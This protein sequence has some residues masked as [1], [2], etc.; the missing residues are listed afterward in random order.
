MAISEITRRDI[1]DFITLN[2]IAWW[3]RLEEPAFLGRLYD[4][5]KLPSDDSRY[6]TASGDIYKHRVANS[7]WPDDWVFSDRRFNLLW[8]DDAQFLR[9]LSETVHPVVRS[10]PSEVTKLVDA[11]NKHLKNDGWELFQKSEISGRA[12]FGA[13]EIAKRVE[14]FDEPTGWPKVDRQI[15]E[16]RLQLHDA[17]AEEQFQAIGLLCREALISLAQAVYVPK[18]H[19]TLDGVEPSSTD[20]K[21]MLEA[22]LS[23]ELVGQTNEEARSHAKTSLKFA[24]ALQHNRTADFRAAA[25]CA[26]ATASVINIVGIVSGARIPNLA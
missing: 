4:L 22:F 19:P 6:P 8:S 25:L 13:R 12:I 14:I 1:I 16:V 15:A 9:F 2:R 11:F 21:R 5:E 17:S 20:A 18:R 23:A 24:I 10:D 3:G 26:E 7:D